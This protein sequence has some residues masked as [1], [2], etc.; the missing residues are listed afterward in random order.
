MKTITFLTIIGIVL[1]LNGLASAFV[2][3]HQ[4]TAISWPKKYFL[5]Q[6]RDEDFTSHLDNLKEQ[7]NELFQEFCKK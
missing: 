2:K 5:H 7:Y 3:Y 1:A 6:E 4:I